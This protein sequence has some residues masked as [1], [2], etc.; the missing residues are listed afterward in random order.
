MV[1]EVLCVPQDSRAI[2]CFFVVDPPRGQQ[3]SPVGPRI[4]QGFLSFQADSCFHLG[5]WFPGRKRKVLCWFWFWSCFP[6]IIRSKQIL[7]LT[8]ALRYPGQAVASLV[9]FSRQND[10][11]FQRWMNTVRP[12][13][14]S[15]FWVNFWDTFPI[16]STKQEVW[17]W[18]C[19]LW[20]FYSIYSSPRYPQSC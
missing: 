1:A 3:P 5:S 6:G 10:A 16:A 20:D 4:Q 7:S 13:L 14:L 17:L 11:T 15:N 8:L 9:F 19:I 18:S 12:P 2:F